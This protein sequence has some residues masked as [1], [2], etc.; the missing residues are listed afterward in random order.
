MYINPP[1]AF[2]IA[3]SFIVT[4]CAEKLEALPSYLNIFGI[5]YWIMLVILIWLSV[6]SGWKAASRERKF[7][8]ENR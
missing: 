1:I 7:E 4:W 3:L 2:Y 5:G 6:S 8:I